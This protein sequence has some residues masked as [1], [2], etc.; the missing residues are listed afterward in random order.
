MSHTTLYLRPLFVAACRNGIP[1]K[2]LSPQLENQLKV[3]QS[4]NYGTATSSQG[5]SV[6]NCNIKQNK[7]HRKSKK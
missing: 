6:H 1:R 7:L 2:F 4:I 3:D 5:P